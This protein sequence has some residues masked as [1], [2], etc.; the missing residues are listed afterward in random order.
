MTWPYKIYVSRAR[1]V[2][3]AETK[4]CEVINLKWCRCED[5][6]YHMKNLFLFFFHYC[7]T[8]KR[9]KMVWYFHCS[10][11]FLNCFQM[12]IAINWSKR[13]VRKCLVLQE[14]SWRVFTILRFPH[15]TYILYTGWSRT[16]SWKNDIFFF[17]LNNDS[18]NLLHT[19]VLFLKSLTFSFEANW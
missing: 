19:A 14:I 18:S 8:E 12:C 10:N 4:S 2:T 1:C 16:I 17:W 13:I 9:K 7:S 11:G 15:Y 5:I 6:Q 3:C